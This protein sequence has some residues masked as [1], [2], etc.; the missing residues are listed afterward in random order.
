MV[1]Y[2]RPSFVYFVKLIYTIYM[3]VDYLEKI[4]SE[5][6]SEAKIKFA[7]MVVDLEGH[8]DAA[9][10]RGEAHDMHMLDELDIINDLVDQLPDCA[11][12]ADEEMP[13]RDYWIAGMKIFEEFFVPT[14]LEELDRLE[15][16]ALFREFENMLSNY[17]NLYRDVDCGDVQSKVDSLRVKFD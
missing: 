3:S 4:D 7:N 13:D 17:S 15:D 1:Q 8:L 10:E 6:R 12:F 16:S 5:D 11:K 9:E 14:A 2:K